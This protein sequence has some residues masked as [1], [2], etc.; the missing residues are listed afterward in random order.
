MFGDN[1]SL[2]GWG[3]VLRTGDCLAGAA[4]ISTLHARNCVN[5]FAEE[6]DATVGDE[7]PPAESLLELVLHQFLGL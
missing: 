5:E 6:N 7:H 4:A 1:L 2:T 3:D